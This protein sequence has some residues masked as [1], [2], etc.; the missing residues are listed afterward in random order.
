MFQTI[1]K[2]IEKLDINARL[3]NY[4]L[5]NLHAFQK[6]GY[7]FLIKGKNVFVIAP[8]G[9]GKTDIAKFAAI[10]S[11][12]LGLLAIYLVPTVMLLHQKVNEFQQEFGDDIKILKLQAEI[13]PT[14][15]ELQ[16]NMG[17]TIIIATYESFRSFLFEIQKRRYFYG[18]KVFGSIIIDEAHKLGD[19]SRGSKLESLLEK[20]QREHMNAQLCFLSGSFEK[21][22][23]EFWAKKFDCELIYVAKD[24]FFKGEIVEKEFG[25]KKYHKDI[26]KEI[27]E[28][29]G[30]RAFH[31]KKFRVLEHCEKFLYDYIKELQ[32]QNQNNK[33]ASRKMLIFT[34]SRR[35]AEIY[36]SF[37]K[38]YMGIYPSIKESENTEEY[39]V[40]NNIDYG[41]EYHKIKEF[42]NKAIGKNELPP[43]DVDFIH[44]GLDL[45]T[46]QE[47]FENFMRDDK[48]KILC[49]SPVL[50]VGVDIKKIHT[51]LLTDAEI[52]TCI[53]ITQMIGRSRE[54]IGNIIFFVAR[55][56]KAEF[57]AKIRFLR[58][59]EL[60]RLGIRIEKSNQ[61]Y[62]K[63][64]KLEEIRSK[65]TLEEIKRLA[66]ER[67]FYHQI[68]FK[69]W[70]NYIKKLISKCIKERRIE[71]QENIK[72]VKNK[73][74]VDN[75]LVKKLESELDKLSTNYI[76]SE[77][78][79]LLHELDATKYIRSSN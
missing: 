62:F 46:R 73:E 7:K 58:N 8:T 25:N 49:C 69:K 48:V 75:D 78:R 22:S 18:T 77:L 13:R 26:K 61:F 5:R 67:L 15:K 31:E 71:L 11:L 24:R 12:V 20:I 42:L 27:R 14:V 6:T 44:A 51:I 47:K 32:S 16:E 19:P 23:A 33:I 4:L 40:N 59:I 30:K 60:K 29:D 17:S 39:Y 28:A 35:T 76:C 37:I 64:F 74:E 1:S 68:P 56:K 79:T 45:E 3:K 53:E 10:L 43:Y 2:N 41:E 70:K 52:Y 57:E 72:N 50:E 21:R 54:E 34:Y 63:G 65:I 66:I 55:D 9:F 38:Q 36:S